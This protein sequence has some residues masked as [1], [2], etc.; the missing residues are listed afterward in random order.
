MSKRDPLT[1]VEMEE[2]I[3]LP[4]VWFAVLGIVGAGIVLHILL[5]IFS[6]GGMMIW[7]FLFAACVLLLVNDASAQNGV[8]VPPFQAY[9]FFFGTLFGVSGFVWLVSKTINPWI[10]VIAIIGICIYLAN[11][12]KKRKIIEREIQR[13]RLAGVCIRCREPVT[14]GLE[15]ICL[16]C[17]LLVHAERLNLFRLGKAIANKNMADKARQTLTGAS[18]TKTQIHQQN[19]H[20][21]KAASYKRK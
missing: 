9:A 12:W 20:L 10:I 2:K 13:R 15:D 18:P 4:K 8:G 16:N 19:L 3:R 14:N 21:R 1:P 6:S 11:D 7:P 17:G 5:A